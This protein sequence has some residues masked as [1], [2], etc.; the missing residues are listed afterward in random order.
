MMEFFLSSGLHA[1]AFALLV[2][3]PNNA[4]FNLVFKVYSSLWEKRL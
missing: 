4:G 2:K 1:S 3:S